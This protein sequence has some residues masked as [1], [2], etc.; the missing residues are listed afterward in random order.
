[1]ASAMKKEPHPNPA[2]KGEFVYKMWA[3]VRD[4]CMSTSRQTRRT[5]LAMDV[6]N[7]A[8]EVVSS[9]MAKDMS[10]KTS[11]GL[12]LEATASAAHSTVPKAKAKGRPA[13]KAK[14]KTPTTDLRKTERDLTNLVSKIAKAG[15]GIEAVAEK[16]PTDRVLSAKLN[17]LMEQGMA[18]VASATKLK[19]APQ[20]ESEAVIDLTSKWDQFRTATKGYLQTAQARMKAAGVV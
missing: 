17:E 5:E 1:M 20:L 6:G 18:L 19:C 11:R 9:S 12:V 15:A 13:A 16:T 3:G 8:A 2:R 4:T 10:S 14:A 7:D